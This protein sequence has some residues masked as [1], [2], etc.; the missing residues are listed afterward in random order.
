M[1][2]VLTVSIIDVAAQSHFHT[3]VKIVSATHTIT[4]GTTFL[5]DGGGGAFTIT[6]PLASLYT[7]RLITIKRVSAS[8]TI[9]VGRSGSDT[10]DGA[11]SVDLTTQYERLSVTSD[12]LNWLVVD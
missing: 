12:G 6:L 7:G 2:Q 11:T 4:G 5:C 3:E 8:G 10:I 1:P 9:T